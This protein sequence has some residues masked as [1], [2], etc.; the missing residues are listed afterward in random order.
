MEIEPASQDLLRVEFQ[1]V[2]ELF[3]ILEQ[4]SD[5]RDIFES[6]GAS[7]GNTDDLPDDSKNQ[8]RLFLDEVLRSDAHN[9]A[10][11]GSGTLNP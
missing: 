1:Q 4:V 11:D 9:S 5:F 6:D 7:D 10:A 3:S 2:L 8:M